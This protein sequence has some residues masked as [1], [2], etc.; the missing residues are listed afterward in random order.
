MNDVN[1]QQFI[2]RILKRIYL[3]NNLH[4]ISIM[5]YHVH[6][7]N[8]L[9]DKIYD[10]P[11]SPPYSRTRVLMSHLA[12]RCNLKPHNAM[13]DCVKLTIFLGDYTYGT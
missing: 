13:Q 8:L 7:Q 6:C 3:E 12:L 4:S 2:G 5:C 10:I 9:K 11:P 1:I